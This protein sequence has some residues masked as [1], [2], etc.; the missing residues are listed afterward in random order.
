MQSAAAY[1]PEM[2]P[3]MP[4]AAVIDGVNLL[5]VPLE[6]LKV[7]AA[8]H[9]MVHTPCGACYRNTG[10]VCVCVE[11]ANKWA[12]VPVIFGTNKNEGTIFVPALV[13]VVPGTKFPPTTANLEAGTLSPDVRSLCRCRRSCIDAWLFSAAALL[14]ALHL[15]H[16][17][18][19][20]RG[21]QRHG[22]VPAICPQ[23]QPV[24]T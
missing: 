8:S 13:V 22:H 16:N 3:I 18:R 20:R 24:G 21:D 2:A 10:R 19:R 7:R 5:E 17:R 14:L 6:S 23:Q 15:E 1:H 11:Q 9:V 4:W 12:D